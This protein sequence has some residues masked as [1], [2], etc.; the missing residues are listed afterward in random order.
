[1]AIGPGT[2]LGP[3]EIVESIGA[4]GMGQVWRATDTRLGRDVAI[5][6]LPGGLAQEPGRLARFEREAQGQGARFR[7]GQGLFGR[8]RRHE[9]RAFAGR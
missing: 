3:Y 7:P 8:R 2:Q 1:M 9:S 4:G 5:K 6:T